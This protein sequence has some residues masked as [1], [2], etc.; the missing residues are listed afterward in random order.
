MTSTTAG[1]M[2]AA[3]AIAGNTKHEDDK[4]SRGSPK[5]GLY[6]AY[7]YDYSYYCST[8]VTKANST[9][10]ER[11]TQPAR[12]CLKQTQAEYQSIDFIFLVRQSQS[13]A[14]SPKSSTL[15]GLSMVLVQ[16]HLPQPVFRSYVSLRLSLAL[17]SPYRYS[18]SCSCPCMLNF[19]AFCKSSSF[20]SSVAVTRP[21]PL[22]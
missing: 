7:L 12:A 15:L 3:T 4:H 5:A 8:T 10:Q 21:L 18:A 19:N 16:S 20:L 13:F 9:T 6:F 2:I 11:V 22:F 17:A 14:S 1:T